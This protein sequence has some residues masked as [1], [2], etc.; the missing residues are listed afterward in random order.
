MG[1]GLSRSVSLHDPRSTISESIPQSYLLDLSV[2]GIQVDKQV[3]P[4][5]RERGHAALVVPIGVHVVHTDRVGAQFG[6]ASDVALAL[7]GVD[8]GIVGCELVGDTWSG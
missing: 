5:I 6:H 4:G 2:E 1:V 7:G 8:E 3:D